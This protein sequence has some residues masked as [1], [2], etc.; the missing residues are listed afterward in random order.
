[1]LL[2]SLFVAYFNAGIPGLC[3]GFIAGRSLLSIG[4]PL[5]V[6]RALQVPLRHQ[7]VNCIR[8]VLTTSLLFLAVW[9]L[10]KQF[11]INTW[12]ELIAACSVTSFIVLLLAALIGLNAEQRDRLWKR[13]NK[14]VRLSPAPAN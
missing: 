4:Y 1:L 6:G 14:V 11:V 2:A 7:V 3:I 12:L 9:M 10:D 13:V 8:P 5:I